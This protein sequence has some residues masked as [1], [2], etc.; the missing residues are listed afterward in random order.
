VDCIEGE[1]AGLCIVSHAGKSYLVASE[2]NRPRNSPPGA[3]LNFFDMT[4]PQ[5]LSRKIALDLRAPAL[6]ERR[7]GIRIKSGCVE[8]VA[9]DSAG[10]MDLISDPAGS[11]YQSLEPGADEK[12]FSS[13]R[14]LVFETSFSDLLDSN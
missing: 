6:D 8:G 11:F 2:R 12:R 3:A 5:T 4:A 1:L 14:P 13:W 7:G 9:S 10:R